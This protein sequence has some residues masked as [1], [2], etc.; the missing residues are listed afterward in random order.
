LQS[1]D[2]SGFYDCFLRGAKHVVGMSLNRSEQLLYDYVQH[3]PDERH[4]WQT[5]VQ[6]IVAGSG[7]LPL[8][9][10]RLD[11]EL[12]RYHEERSAVVPAF[13]AASRALGGKRISMK[14]L[15]EHLVRL[16]TE[17]KPKKPAPSAENIP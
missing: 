14:N 15:A 17:P 3:H 6:T 2:E 12:W 10:A 13:A 11:S 16:W 9:V 4:Y 7:E 8:A 5:K 1:H